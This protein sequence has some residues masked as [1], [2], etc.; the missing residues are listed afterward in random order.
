MPLIKV[1]FGYDV[2][3]LVPGRPLFIGGVKIPFSKGLLGHSDADVLLHALCDAMLGACGLGDLGRHFPDKDPNFKDISSLLLLERV[4]HMVGKEG[5]FL[6]NADLTL[7]AQ[8]PK[9]LPYAEKMQKKIAQAC[10]VQPWVINVKATT[11]EGLGITGRGE[12]MAAYAVA[13]LSKAG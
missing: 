3:R 7:V 12:A 1:G 11:T 6:S 9:I 2:H 10:K 5:F 13:T 4:N 8:E